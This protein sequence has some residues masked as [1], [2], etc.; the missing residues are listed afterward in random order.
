MVTH[1]KISVIYFQ[2]AFDNANDSEWDRKKQHQKVNSPIVEIPHLDGLQTTGNQGNNHNHMSNLR[3]VQEFLHVLV[4]I[5]PSESFHVRTGFGA[6]KVGIY[7]I[8]DIEQK[9]QALYAREHA[10]ART[11][12]SSYHMCMRACTYVCV[13]AHA[14]VHVRGC[15]SKLKQ[16]EI[17][18]Y[19]YIPLCSS[20]RLER[21]RS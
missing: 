19:M 2:L 13:C 4:D 21:R 6:Y 1:N 15:G 3:K 7:L 8:I 9:Q 10:H 16:A 14:H 11:I 12:V 17:C 18:F 5:D 20:T